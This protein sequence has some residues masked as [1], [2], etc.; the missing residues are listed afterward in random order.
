MTGELGD[1]RYGKSSIRLAVV[2]RARD[3]H[4]FRDVT[5]DVALTGDFTAAH[6]E[7]DNADVLPTDTMRA[8]V[9]ALAKR[10]GVGAVEDFG[11]R[12][13]EHF[14]DAAP[15]ATRAEVRLTEQPW[16]RLR[17]EGADHPHAFT[18]PAGGRRT[19]VATSRRG[20]GTEVGSGITDWRLLKTTGSGF[21]GFLR[22]AYTMLAETDDRVLA[23]TVTAD[24]RYEPGA[25]PD[26][27][28][29]ADSVRDACA[30][31]FATTYS[32]SVQHTLY[33][34]GQAALEACREV[35]EIS[36]SLPNQHHFPVDLRPYGLSNDGDVLVAAQQPFGLIEGTVVRR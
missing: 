27:S 30:T 10:D 20:S 22:D 6:V 23:T 33:A 4:T 14:L 13:T 18:T 7:G 17:V 28:R 35:R 24:W 21:G 15:A 11:R 36:F 26:F 2:E 8:T 25:I 5:V 31:V 29:V 19:A 9:Y 3:R 1:N 32:P 34:M 12:L 16:E